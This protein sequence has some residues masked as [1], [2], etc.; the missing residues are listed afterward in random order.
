[1]I[2]YVLQQISLFPHMTIE[3]NIAIVPALTKWSKDKI[4]DRITELLESVGLAPESYLHRTPAELSG[5]EQQRG[6]AGRP[7][8]AD[9]GIIVMAEPFSAHDPSSRQRSQQDIS[10]LQNK[11]QQPSAF[12]T[13]HMP[14]ALALG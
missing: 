6:G 9:P 7:P 13:H 5:G 12:G 8:A 11:I 4:H 1:A 14:E 3:E 2:G 10:A